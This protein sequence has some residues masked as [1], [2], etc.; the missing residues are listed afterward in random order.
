MAR[1]EVS[2]LDFGSQ[3]ITVLQGSRDVN[4]SINIRGK[5]SE[6][7]EGFIDGEFIEPKKLETVVFSCLTHLT[8]FSMGKPKILTIGVPTEF[9]YCMC[10]TVKKT[11]Q[12]TKKITRKDIDF[13]YKSAFTAIKDHTLIN[14]DSVYYVLGENNKVKN[15]IGCLDSKITACLSFI[16]ADNTFIAQVSR[17]LLKFGIEKF[18]FVSST[19][20]QSLYLFDEEER[21]KYVLMVDCGYITTSVSLLRGNGILNLSSFSLGGGHIIADLSR[22][23]KIPFESAQTLLKKIVLSIEPDDNDTYD[24]MV[25]KKVIPISMKVANAI[26]ESRIE[27]I[28]QG[29]QKSFNLWQYN[30]PDFI[31]IHLTGGGISFIKGGKDVLSRVLGKNVEIISMPYSQFNKTNYSSCVAVLNYALNV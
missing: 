27:V 24:I 18:N 22:C 13:L 10:K 15:P 31:P 4:N 9:C 17:I 11:F 2:I 7:Y 1:K 29:I 21:N 16:L 3:K 12:N 30:F 20:A 26:V 28:A 19:Y 5:Y 14:Q 25:D 8:E 6:N 23:L